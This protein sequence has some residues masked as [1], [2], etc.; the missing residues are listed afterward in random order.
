M[1]IRDSL[2]TNNGYTEPY[3]SM[4]VMLQLYLISIQEMD[5]YRVSKLT[6]KLDVYKRQIFRF[7]SI[8]SFVLGSIWRSYLIANRRA[9]KIRSPSSWNRSSGFPTCLLYT[10]TGNCSVD[11]PC[12]R[13]QKTIICDVDGIYVSVFERN[14]NDDEPKFGIQTQYPNNVTAFCR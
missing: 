6:L 7:L 1:C 11:I 4:M 12:P 2:I 10:S 9:R 14:E 5:H 8:A 13:C 3:Y